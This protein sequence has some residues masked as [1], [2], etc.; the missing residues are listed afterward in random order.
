MPTY[1]TSYP[2]YYICTQTT[3]DNGTVKWTTVS[4]S[5]ALED[6]NST[7]NTANTNASNAV[8]TANTANTN[9]SNAVST[10]NTANTNAS[11]AVTTANQAKS[12]ADSAASLLSTWTGD[13]TLATTTIDG[14]YIKTHTI[15]STHLATNAI[16]SQNYLRTDT[17][18]PYSSTGA[19]L[20]LET[21]TLYMPNFGVNGTTGASYFN[22][23]VNANAG[24]FGDDTSYWNI[25]TVYDYNMQPHAALVGTGSPYLQTG[26]WQV[27]DNAVATRKYT[28]T[29]ESAGNAT[30]YKDSGTNTFYDVGM[31]IPTNFGGYS[32]SDSSV[33][34]YNKAFYY[35]RKY[36][37]NSVP[38]LDSDWTYFFEIDSGGN[39]ITAGDVYEGGVKLS[40]KYAAITDVG[41]AYLPK[42]GGTITGNLTINGNFSTTVKL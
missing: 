41:S 35:G 16:M 19:F 30:Y 11:N 33:T 29:S 21:G 36:T 18:S 8:S 20:D 5:K 25:E 42:T 32:A 27:S 6:A 4:R 28:S 13:A 39:I 26:N 15:E 24:K 23:I 22:G 9:A 7:A 3:Y 1:N 2:Y 12:K 40:E 14:G 38:S 10:A 37:G 17:S 31:K 34:R